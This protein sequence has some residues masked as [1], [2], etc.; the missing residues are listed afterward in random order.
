M[1]KQFSDKILSKEE[2][3]LLTAIWRLQSESFGQ[4]VSRDEVLETTGWNKNQFYGYYN[5]LR[6]RSEIY[7]IE[8]GKSYGL[9]D[10]Y[11]ITKSLTARIICEVERFIKTHRDVCPDGQVP[12]L[13]FI[14]WSSM[15]L[16][17]ANDV[18]I[19]KINKLIA[20]KYLKKSQREEDSVY[21]EF[22]ERKVIERAWIEFLVQGNLNVSNN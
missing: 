6:K 21:I 22:G 7:Y 4:K 12:L 5:E 11:L 16:K 18:V 10:K 17:I 15:E 14:A 13:D 9:A 19:K 8:G 1:A 3:K 20:R 2:I